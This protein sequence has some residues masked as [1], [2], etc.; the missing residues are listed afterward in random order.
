MFFIFVHLDLLFCYSVFVPTLIV[1]VVIL[2]VSQYRFSDL[3]YRLGYLGD[4]TQLSLTSL[5][6]YEP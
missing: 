4:S 5:S 2:V 3:S 6:F 1:Y